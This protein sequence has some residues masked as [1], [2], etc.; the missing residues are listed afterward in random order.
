MS[1]KSDRS[2]QSLTSSSSAY[3]SDQWHNLINAVSYR[4][5]REYQGEAFELPEEVEMLPIFRDRIAGTLQAKMT[6]PFWEL[7]K[8]Q[9]NQHCLDIG[10]GVSF[11]IYP[12]RDW[13]ALFYG[14]DISTVAIDA[15]NARGPQLNSKLFK[16]VKLGAAHHL[17]YEADQ[18][19]L[20]IATGFSCYYPLEYWAEVLA[21]VKRVLKPTGEFV[22]D[23]LNPEAPLAED[24]AILETYLGTEVFLESLE[25][26]EKTIKSTGAKIVKKKPGELFQLYKICF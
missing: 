13:N 7:A 21:E 23:V 6:S 10:C 25:D 3:L 11:L 26:W 24:W 15:L 16:G 18:F 4:F 12:W 14:Q 8:I 5:N 17:E 9:K 2:S 19:D 22:F 1:K 20:A